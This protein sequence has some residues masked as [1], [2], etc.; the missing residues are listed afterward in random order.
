MEAPGSET[1][2]GGAGGGDGAAEG[3]AGLLGELAGA[4]KGVADD[5]RDFCAFTRVEKLPRLPDP[6]VFMRDYVARSRPVVFQDSVADW[7][8]I[9]RWQRDE[10]LLSIIGGDTVTVNYTPNGRGDAVRPCASDPA[11]CRALRSSSLLFLTTCC[12]PCTGAGEAGEGGRVCVPR[13]EAH[14]VFRVFS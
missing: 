14:D 6:L 2:A 10:Y 3:A 7:P 5:A 12:H 13:G 11:P 9:E 1:G 4:L 8:A